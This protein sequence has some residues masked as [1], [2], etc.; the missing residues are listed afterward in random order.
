MDN[1]GRT[2]LIIRKQNKDQWDCTLHQFIIDEK[3]FVLIS[4]TPISFNFANDSFRSNGSV[5][6]GG[7]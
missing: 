3:K 2:K 6:V 7:H 5:Y 4:E 1:I